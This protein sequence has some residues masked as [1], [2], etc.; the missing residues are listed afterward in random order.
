[1]S[2][3]GIKGMLFDRME[4][5]QMPMQTLTRAI[6]A[7]VEAAVEAAPAALEHVTSRDG[8]TIGYRRLGRGPGLVLVQGAMGT[9]QHFTEL[10]GLLADSF[11]VYLPDRRGRGLSSSSSNGSH[12]PRQEVEDLQA[13][14]VG[15]DAELV[16]GLSSGGIIALEAALVTPSLRRLA[17]FEPP[18]LLNAP[19][20][21][22]LLRRYESEIAGGREAAALVTGMQASQLAPPVFN[23]LPRWLL[24]RLTAA[25]LAQE[26]RKGSGNYVPMRA[27]AHSLGGDFAVVAETAGPL[28]RYG[29]IR[30]D[31]LLLGGSKSPRFL[32]VAL[33]ALQKALPGARRVEL[34]GLGHAASW[35]V[36]RRGTPG[37]VAEELRRFFG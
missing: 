23:V 5:V 37:P 10:A 26:D 16:F 33:D 30:A 13:V 27:L 1:M 6:E 19:I 18:F 24:E 36:D 34:A 11:T 8:T 15:T 3:S 12:G 20:P 17:V 35:N 22:K 29:A 14:L 31:V 32:N 28:D 25:M 9:A 7:A 21:T 4:V 2:R